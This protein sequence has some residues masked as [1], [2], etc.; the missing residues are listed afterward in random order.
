MLEE[1]L[2]KLEAEVAALKQ[3]LAVRIGLMSPPP[4]APAEEKSRQRRKQ[5]AAEE[6]GNP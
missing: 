3:A 5:D 6:K 2:L 4:S 1:R